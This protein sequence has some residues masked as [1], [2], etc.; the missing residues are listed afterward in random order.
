MAVAQS[1]QGAAQIG[2]TTEITLAAAT[3]YNYGPPYSNLAIAP[4]FSC[5]YLYFDA[6]SVLRA[7]MV[8]VADLAKYATACLDAVD[9]KVAP[10]GQ[11]LSIT[12]YP[13]AAKFDDVPPVAR[14][15]WD[16]ESRK[17]YIGIKCSAETWCDIGKTGVAGS[18]SY[19]LG[20]APTTG[21]RVVR[22]KGW[23]DEQN[24]GWRTSTTAPVVPSGIVGTVIPAVNLADLKNPPAFEQ[25]VTVAHVALDASA[26]PSAVPFMK[27][28]LNL[29]PVSVLSHAPPLWEPK[30]LNKL[31]L[32]FGT[33]GSCRVSWT[34]E[35][36]DVRC[37]SRAWFGWPIHRWYV[38]IT[39][40]GESAAKFRCVRRH[41][42]EDFPLPIPGTT[43]WR[44]IL[45]DETI[46]TE[47][48]QGC[49]Q[50][51]TKAS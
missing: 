26:A 39:A 12:R 35:P 21:D 42:H 2:K 24:L 16:R 6:T 20:T 28:K 9:P 15:D 27:K 30:R 25:F 32:C 13:R 31:E 40:A 37:A 29:N 11:L 22:V 3:I 1:V 49:C 5:L 14:W 38:R 18:V 41:G 4:N 23:Y 17:Y 48:T 7:K 10:G 47:C 33:Q 51:E 36:E 44:W 50:T 8:P 45:D 43:R 46:W 19:L 34:T